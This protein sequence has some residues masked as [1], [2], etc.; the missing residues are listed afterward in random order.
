[1]LCRL[2]V[3]NYALIEEL[4]FEP[5]PGFNII[6][7]ETGAGKSIL[8][9]ALGLILGNRADMQALRDNSQKC[10]VE[11]TFKVNLEPVNRFLYENNLDVCDELI[12]RR[13]ILPGGKSRA[14]VNDTPVNLNALKIIGDMLV[15][16]HS[17]HENLL[18]NEAQFQLAVLD[19]FARN[20][21]ILSSYY[22]QYLD[23]R[24]KTTKL[25][26]LSEQ[27]AKSMAEQDFIHFQLDELHEAHIEPGEQAKIENELSLLTHA[28]EIK[29]RLSEM[30][31]ILD[32]E[33]SGVIPALASQFSNLNS[34][35]RFDEALK[36][37]E[38]RYTSCFYE[39]KDILQ[40]LIKYADTI[41]YT[42]DRIAALSQRLDILFRLQ[43]K[44]RVKD[45][46]E[47]IEVKEHF[48]EK[49]N[50]YASLNEQIES[51]QQ[52]IIWIE[53]ELEEKANRL[54]DRRKAAIQPIQH[55][56]K[57]SLS[58]LGM[59]D[60]SIEVVLESTTDFIETGKNRVNF[61]FSANVGQEPRSISKV[62]SGGEISRL[63]L[64]IKSLISNK[65]MIPVL[66]FDEIDAGVSG[67]IAAKAGRLMKQMA[68][69]MQIIAITHIP[70]I[71]ALGD[72]HFLVSKKINKGTT[73]SIIERL[74]TEGR[75]RELAGMLSNHE[76]TQEAIAAA[77]QLL[78]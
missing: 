59:P 20:K 11:G 51:L 18:V 77:K 42:P 45:A 28:E 69:N 58:E 3:K 35:I 61:L 54:S 31:Q 50:S 2:S 68:R 74:S 26:L 76:I 1:M 17:Q 7:G 12:M 24:N 9:G 34:L 72:N 21:E 6:T 78:K 13:E 57:E 44:H 43:Q 4:E 33:D 5:G 29:T 70:Q 10:I 49:L 30:I 16:I 41:H 63:M 52:E 71:A 48:I 27:E 38:S 19:D 55:Q 65:T 36:E 56:L 47:L 14:F 67:G 62:A 23:Y 15:D 64:A 66:I 60:A 32:D 53:G 25:E 46:D 39:L 22:A 40:E 8:L 75:I 37:I 73:Q